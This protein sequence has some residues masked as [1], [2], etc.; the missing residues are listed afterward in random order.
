MR[1]SVNDDNPAPL[2]EAVTLRLRVD[3]CNRRFRQTFCQ[4]FQKG[5]QSHSLYSRNPASF[6][7][8]ADL[9]GFS[10]SVCNTP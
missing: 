5:R 6:L 2:I 10:V 4:L 8:R 3:P 1:L 7:A 9:L